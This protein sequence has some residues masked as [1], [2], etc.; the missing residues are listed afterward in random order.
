MTIFQ[1]NRNIAEH[2]KCVALGVIKVNTISQLT[3]GLQV[4]WFTVIN[5]TPYIYILDNMQGNFC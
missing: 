2:D 1:R 5:I 3:K 4:S